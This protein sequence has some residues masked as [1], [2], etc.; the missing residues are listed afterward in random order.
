[1]VLFQVTIACSPCTHLLKRILSNF[2][3]IPTIT[4]KAQSKR[5]T[6]GIVVGVIVVAVV[7]TLILVVI[8]IVGVVL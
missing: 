3:V 8:I 7:V 1:M 5:N 4:P 2:A 6:A